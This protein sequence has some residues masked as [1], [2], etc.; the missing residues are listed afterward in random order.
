MF[1]A[2]WP[3]AIQDIALNHMVDPVRVYVGFEATMGS[4]RDQCVDDSITANKRVE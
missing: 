3:V 2:I 1:S 4:N